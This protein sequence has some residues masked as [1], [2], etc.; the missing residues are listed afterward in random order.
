MLSCDEYKRKCEDI[1]YVIN[2]VQ[3]NISTHVSLE[4]IDAVIRN[5]TFGKA[6]GPD[7][8]TAEDL[9][10]FYSALIMHLFYLIWSIFTHVLC[11]ISSGMVSVFSH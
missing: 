8:L 2:T 5:L 7:D 11:L 6:C 4:V 3:Y 10:Y 1:H 9:Y